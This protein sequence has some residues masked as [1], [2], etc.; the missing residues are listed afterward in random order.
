VNEADPKNAIAWRAVRYGTPVFSVDGQPAGRVAEVLGS[1]A[2]D[3]FHGIRVQLGQSRRE[4]Q[5]PASEV[6][7]LTVDRVET[8]LSLA[9]LDALPAFSEETTFHLASVGWLRRHLGWKRDSQSDE[10]PG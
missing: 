8:N 3:I 1:D 7:R 5:V 4:V 10:E 9:A 2:E 6:G